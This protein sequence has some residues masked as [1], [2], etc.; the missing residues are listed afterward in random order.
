[1]AA[2]I[3]LNMKILVVDDS[4]TMRRI[5]ISALRKCGFKNIVSADDGKTAWPH[6]EQGGIDLILSDQ[7]MPDVGGLE[8]LKMV[9]GNKGT[10]DL[11]FIMITAEAYREN[12]MEALK[13]GVSNYIVK[14]FN[15]N[16]LVQKIVKVLDAS[17]PQ[18]G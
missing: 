9:R 10:K 14:P 3:D 15:A 18:R 5:V 17:L 12:V 1:M 16:Q 4:A 8:L 13:L 2:E 7:K 11:P 6:I